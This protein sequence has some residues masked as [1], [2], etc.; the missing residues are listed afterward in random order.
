[1]SDILTIQ[2]PR[3]YEPQRPARNPAYLRWIKGQACIVCKRTYSVDPCHTGPHGMSTKSSDYSCIPL[4]RQH[5][6]EYDAAPYDFQDAHALDIANL[7]VQYQ[8]LWN[9][10]QARKAA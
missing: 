5:H 1:M 2:S 8:E 9:E 3:L 4:C 6:D 7:T 10:R